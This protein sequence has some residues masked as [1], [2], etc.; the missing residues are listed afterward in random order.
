MDVDREMWAKI[1]SNLLSNALKFTFEGEISVRLVREGDVVQL[2][3]R[4]TGIGIQ[5]EDQVHLFERFHRIE[6]ARSRTFEGSGIGLALVAELVGL[7]GGS[8]DATSAPGARA[9]RSPS[10]FPWG[11]RSPTCQ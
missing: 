2:A 8:I 1:V 10:A 4:D 6:G 5:A 3:V 11:R 9:A 7:H